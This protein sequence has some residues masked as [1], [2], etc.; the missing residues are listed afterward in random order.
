MAETPLLA[1]EL[2]GFGLRASNNDVLEKLIQLGIKWHVD[3]GALVEKYVAFQRN[4]DLPD[5]ILLRHVEQFDREISSKLEITKHRNTK[6]SAPAPIT[7]KLLPQKMLEELMATESQND[8]LHLFGSYIPNSTV[9]LMSASPLISATNKENIVPSTAS[10]G[11]DRIESVCSF[12]SDVTHR[13][14]KSCRSPLTEWKVEILSDSPTPVRYMHQPTLEKAEA[15]DNWAWELVKQIISRLPE[16]TFSE[17]ITYTAPN[18]QLVPSASSIGS[19]PLRGALKASSSQPVSKVTGCLE[20]TTYLRSTSVRLQTSSLMAGRL[21]SSSST[22]SPQLGI[23][24]GEADLQ[25]SKNRLQL[26][27]AA[28]VGLRR[29]EGTGAA[30]EATTKLELPITNISTYSIYSGQPVV[31]RATN[32]TGQQLNVTEVYTPSVVD[33]PE[34]VTASTDL[35]VMIATGPFTFANSNDPSLLLTFLRA[36]KRNRPHVLI[37]FGPFVDA[38]HPIVQSYCDSTYEELFQSRLNSVSEYCSHLDVQLV[39]V[40]SWREAHHDPVYPTPPFNSEWTRQTAELIGHYKNVHFVWDPSVISIGGYV[41][42]LT[43]VDVLFHLSSEEISAGCSGDRMARLCQ[44]LLSSR[45]FYPVHPPADDLPLDYILWSQRA[46]LSAAPHCLI[47][48]SRL[49]QFAKDI[50]GVLCIN[51]GHVSRGQ[52][53]G[54]YATV[55]IHA[56]KPEPV[57]NN[58]SDA[59][60]SWSIINRTAVHVHRL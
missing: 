54:S 2:R 37:M 8:Q 57:G 6:M 18:S 47:C 10:V 60:P 19:S 32:P 29:V 52:T 13:F 27:N 46:K 51:P 34:P 15:L 22:T 33:F 25:I 31:L 30:A 28:I 23:E 38:A 43:S 16:E 44:H 50:D 56:H 45:T 39:I 1:E 49:R 3:E 20:R 26:S 41:F 36:V 9:P 24:T 55:T 35:C 59:V 14:E 12:P 21:T 17:S 48:P 4:G 58:P 40:P 7:P 42:G 11:S 53:P 5:E